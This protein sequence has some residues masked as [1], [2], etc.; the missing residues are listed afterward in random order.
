MDRCG[1]GPMMKTARLQRIPSSLQQRWLKCQLCVTAQW[2]GGKAQRQQN[3]THLG[4]GRWSNREQQP[5]AGRLMMDVRKSFLMRGMVQAFPTST[6]C[7]L[8]IYCRK[9][10]ITARK[11][12]LSNVRWLGSVN[13]MDHWLCQSWDSF[14]WKKK[15]LCMK[16]LSLTNFASWRFSEEG[17]PC[18]CAVSCVFANI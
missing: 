1:C 8:L 12:L 6:S 11:V 4:R 9:H 14:W 15:Y 13:F 10:A 16:Q 17:L 5:Q 7:H 18:L 3:Q 2:L